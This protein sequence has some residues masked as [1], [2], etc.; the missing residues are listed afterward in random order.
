MNKTLR[1]A[2]PTLLTCLAAVGTAATAVLAVKETPKALTLLEEKKK[3]TGKEKLT[4][5]ETVK[6]VAPCY[7][8]A[9]ATGV[10]TIVCI[11]GAN[12]LNR[13][14]QASLVSAYGLLNQAYKSYRGGVKELYGEE[15]HEAVLDTV[16]KEKCEDICISAPG[17]FTNSTLDFGDCDPSETRLFYDVCSERYFESTKD[18]VVQAEYHLNRNFLFRGYASL[19]EF[20]ELLGLKKTEDGDVVGWNG[21]DGD[22]YWIDFDHHK[23]T[24]DDGLECFIIDVVYP[25]DAS[26]LDDI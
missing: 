10:S 25:P 4:V 14:Q 13:R 12:V 16:A 23:T 5:V 20:Y 7:I 11:F 15:G 17:M 22:L 1:K 24:L 21:A 8:P 6:T 9:A 19:N 18:R 3:E 26:Y 2:V